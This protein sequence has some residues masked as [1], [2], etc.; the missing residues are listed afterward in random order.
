MISKLGLYLI[1]K[2]LARMLDFWLFLTTIVFSIG[3][4]EIVMSRGGSTSPASLIDAFFTR[5]DDLPEY[6][7]ETMAYAG[8]A[9]FIIA[10]W[11][12][13]RSRELQQIRLMGAT[14]V[15][16]STIIGAGAIFG[17]L[18]VF[19]IAPFASEVRIQQKDIRLVRKNQSGEQLILFAKNYNTSNGLIYG[20]ARVLSLDNSFNLRAI[21]SA[22]KGKITKNAWTLEKNQRRNN[23]GAQEIS[24]KKTFPVKTDMIALANVLQASAREISIYNLPA[25]YTEARINE[26]SVRPFVDRALFFIHLPL[27]Y[28][29]FGLIAYA[30]ALYLTPRGTG[31]QLVLLVIFLPCT[32]KFLQH[33]LWTQVGAASLHAV[34]PTFGLPLAFCCAAALSVRTQ[35]LFI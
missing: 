11:A 6:L 28:I 13:S 19:V 32:V 31:M 26:R 33:I 25:A 1:K 14:K 23:A 2:F 18:Q 8:Y 12:L 16:I 30:A 21:Y 9:G 5:I 29:A 20:G 22:E 15:L 34:F 24:E 35:R 10:F 7:N 17:M 4:I 3:V 27:T